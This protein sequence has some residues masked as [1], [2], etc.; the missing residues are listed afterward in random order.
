MASIHL[1]VL[2]G[3][4]DTVY[5]DLCKVHLQSCVLTL[6]LLGVRPE[7]WETGVGWRK[8]HSVVLQVHSGFS[9][10]ENNFRHFLGILMTSAFG[11]SFYPFEREQN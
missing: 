5:L 7:G 6:S 4:Q 3:R 8:Y 2:V 10:A 9:Q 11:Q 1:E